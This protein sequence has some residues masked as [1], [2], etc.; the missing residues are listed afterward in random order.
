MFM[1]KYMV[2]DMLF[3]IKIKSSVCLRIDFS[4]SSADSFPDRP[5]PPRNLAVTDI[6]AESCYLT[7]DAPLDNGGSEITHYIIDKRDASRKKSEWEEV[8]NTAVEKRYGV[9]SFK[10][11]LVHIKRT[12]P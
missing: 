2:S 7:W 12:C 8:T 6:K 9:N 10:Y 3:Y 5:S 4:I 1:L 11:F